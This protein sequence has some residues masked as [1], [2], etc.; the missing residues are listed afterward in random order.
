MSLPYL[1]TQAAEPPATML[2]ATGAL[3]ITGVS[4]PHE[5]ILEGRFHQK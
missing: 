2:P 3:T 5:T 4:G 1:T